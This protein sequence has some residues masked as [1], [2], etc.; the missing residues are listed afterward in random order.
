VFLG[1]DG[2]T[3]QPIEQV[4]ALRAVPNLLVIRP[5]DANE[6]ATAWRVAIEERHRPTALI[7]TRQNVPTH[8][9]TAFASAEGLRQGAYILADAA[10][11]K[12]D[13]ILI[14]SG[15]EVSLAVEARKR[16]QDQQVKVRVVSMPSW[17]LFD[18]Q[19]R[20][21]RDAV[22]PPSVKARLAIEAGISQGWHRYVGHEG[23]V[24]G[25]DRFGTSAPG[26]VVLR[27]FGFTV[28]N[29]CQ[30]AL[31]LLHHG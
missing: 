9:R 27:E 29:V 31:A 4:G 12:P 10:D 2:P 13:V 11:G 28:E 22:F 6:T 14:A 17:E 23:D 24:I 5:C 21:Y 16:L 30:R 8:D 1:E 3:H 19:P 20:Q 18:E 15:S 25:I 7:L 26:G